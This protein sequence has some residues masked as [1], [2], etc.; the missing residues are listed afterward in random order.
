[1]EIQPILLALRRSKTGAILVAAQVALTLAIVCN[2]LFV[3]KARLATANRP[4]GVAEDEVFQIMYAAAAEIDDRK[5]MQQADLQALRSIPG[6]KKV[7]A[8]NSMPVSTSG[9]GMGMTLDG[10]PGNELSTGVYFSGESYVDALGLKLVAGRD[11]QE[12]EV[13]EIDDRKD[14]R[15]MAGS[16]ILSRHL[17]RKLFKDERAAI[18]KTVYQGSGPEANPMQVVGVVETLMTSSARPDDYAYDSFI[19]PVRFLGATAH[20]AVR[21]EASQ[22]ARVMKDAE[23]ALGTLRTDRVMVNLR[24]ME[25]IKFQ[26][27]RHERAGANMLIAVTIGL[28]LV[29]ASGIVGVASLWVS[30]RRKQIGVRRALGAKRRDIV[31]YFLTENILITTAGIGAGLALAVGLNVFLVSKLEL[32]RLPI[33]YL[34]GGMIAV[35]ALGVIAVIGPAWRAATVPP[36]IATRSA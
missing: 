11:F 21:A 8:I 9:W 23:K 16:V 19:L 31:R 35:W 29:T 24:T 36:A 7:A 6:V 4:S 26:R 25:E 32:A 18:G 10:K 27:Y 14:P 3:V 12:S 13:R 34:I 1:M 22:R 5:G 30:Q 33:E 20:Y 17:A 2:A 15:V 28:L